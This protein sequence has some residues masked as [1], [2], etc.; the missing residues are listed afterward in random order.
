MERRGSRAETRAR[1]FV[2]FSHPL[3]VL[4]C[5]LFVLVLRYRVRR[6]RGGSAMGHASPGGKRDALNCLIAHA[7]RLSPIVTDVGFVRAGARWV[8]RC[9]LPFAMVYMFVTQYYLFTNGKERAGC[10]SV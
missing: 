5:V 8:A 2:Q 6:P 9:S 1:L 10:Y 3:P 7:R 4:C